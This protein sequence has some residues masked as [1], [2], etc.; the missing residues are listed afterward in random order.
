MKHYGIQL[1]SLRDITAQDFFGALAAVADMGYTMVESAGFFGHDAKEV[2]EQLDQL[3]LTICSTHTGWDALLND[4]DATVRYHQEVGC[5]DLI[6][7]G[8]PHGNQ[9]EIDTLVEKINDWQPRLAAEGITLHY[10]N[11]HQEFLPNPDGSVTFSALETRTNVLFELDTYWAFIAGEDP[12]ALL[13]RLGE[14]VRF[15]HLKDGLKN[16]QG[17]SLGQGEAPIAVV[18]ARAQA[19]GRTIVVES[20]GLDPSGKEEVARCIEYLKAQE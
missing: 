16:H 13:D 19:T 10:H 7:P 8:A 6:L 11:H 15:I 18:L 1:Y 12:V 5:K 4:F 17:K 20:E 2:K 3:G 9:A 14:R